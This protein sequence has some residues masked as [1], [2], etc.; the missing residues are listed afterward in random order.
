M[1]T[2]TDT[3]R[4]VDSN[5]EAPDSAGGGLRRRIVR[6]AQRLAGGRSHAHV[7][8]AAEAT[9]ERMEAQPATVIRLSHEE[10]E[11]LRAIEAAAAQDDRPRGMR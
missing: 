1:T 5:Q 10:H 2:D 3:H 8:A 11:Q 6:R 7:I 4:I 9:A